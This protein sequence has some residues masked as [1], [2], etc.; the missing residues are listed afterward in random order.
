MIA[1]PAW[2][3]TELVCDWQLFARSPGKAHSEGKLK[4]IVAFDT[5][6]E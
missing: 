3:A 6:R 2:N 5:L 4:G 1:D